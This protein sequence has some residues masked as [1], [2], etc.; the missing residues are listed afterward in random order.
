MALKKKDYELIQHS[1]RVK[2]KVRGINQSKSLII[3]LLG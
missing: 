2:N 3:L 1:Q